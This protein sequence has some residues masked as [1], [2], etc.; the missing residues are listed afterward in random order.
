[1][2]SDTCFVVI[3]I[4]SVL[5]VVVVTVFALFPGKFGGVVTEFVA[6]FVAAYASGY[7]SDLVNG[8]VAVAI[9]RF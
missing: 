5:R 7:V 9:E 3:V 6:T 4:F 2:V 1:M 8:Y